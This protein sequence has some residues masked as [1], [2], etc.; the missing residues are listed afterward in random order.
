[1]TPRSCLSL[2][3]KSGTTGDGVVTSVS[4]FSTVAYKM[5]DCSLSK[6]ILLCVAN[7]SIKILMS[8]QHLK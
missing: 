4:L 8:L 1:M 2:N 7:A 6:P 5:A 3:C